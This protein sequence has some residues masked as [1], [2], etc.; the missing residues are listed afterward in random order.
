MIG[1][2]SGHYLGETSDKL[3]I[4][5]GPNE[6]D[7]LVIGDFDKKIMYF[8]GKVGINT[9]KP[10]YELDVYGDINFTGNLLLNGEK[11]IS[12]LENEISELKEKINISNKT[13]NK[14]QNRLLLVFT[15]EPRESSKVIESQRINA[16]QILKK[17][18][19]IKNLAISFEYLLKT[20]KFNSIGK[21]FH[22]HW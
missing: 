4:A 22:N 5:S 14:F 17:Y 1:N 9:N 20:E 7:V 3:I 6:N 13:L 15:K 11:I 18:D 10:I 19:L 8:P 12:K 16:K 2:K 21:L